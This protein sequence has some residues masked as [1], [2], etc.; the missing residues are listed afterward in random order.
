MSDI[1]QQ[2]FM[3]VQMNSYSLN[4]APQKIHNLESSPTFENGKKDF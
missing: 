3:I 4:K 1:V 2:L